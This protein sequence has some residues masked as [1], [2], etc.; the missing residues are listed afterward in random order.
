MVTRQEEH[1]IDLVPDRECEHPAQVLH[2]IASMI[3]VEVKD[4]LDVGLGLEGVAGARQPL[5]QLRT[6]VDLAIADKLQRA[7]L[8]RNRLFSTVEVNNAE[9]ALAE[10]RAFIGVEATPIRPA[11]DHRL[12]HRADGVTARGRND[13]GDSAHA[14]DSAPGYR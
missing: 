3:L 14:V 10:R 2:A 9:P 5:A 4:D 7:C 8:V 11:V 13:S 1:P 6:V 12:S